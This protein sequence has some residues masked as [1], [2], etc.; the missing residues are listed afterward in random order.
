MSGLLARPN[1][2]RVAPRYRN[3][4]VLATCAGLIAGPV[5]GAQ[6]AHPITLTGLN[7]GTVNVGEA[8]KV[9]TVRF[10][11]DTGG[12]LDSMQPFQVVTQGA[13][14]L[15]FVSAAGATCNGT[16]SYS[17]G[18]TCQVNVRFNPK[19]PGPRYGAVLLYGSAGSVIATAY[20]YGTGTGP[21]VTFSPGPSSSVPD[22]SPSLLG[23]AVDASGDVFL[24]HQKGL[25][26]KD[27]PSGGGYIQSTVGDIEPNNGY[28]NGITVDGAGNIFATNA[29]HVY[30]ESPSGT[31]YTQSVAFG[32]LANSEQIAVD[33]SG[34]LFITEIEPGRVV[35]AVPSS[36]GY[37][38]SIIATGILLPGAITVD[39]S[40]NVYVG[41]RQGSPG[42][43]GGV[44]KLTQ[45]G[46]TYT[47]ST[48]VEALSVSGVAV[49]AAGDVYFSGAD[50]S[51]SSGNYPGAVY[52]AAP[53]A[54]GYVQGT[55]VSGL[56]DPGS[57]E[58]DQSGN[59]YVINNVVNDEEV[60]KET[61][62]VPPSLAFA[63]TA[64]GSISS[65]S[66]QT[67]TVSNIG[68]ATLTFPV[69]ESGDNPAISENFTLDSGSDAE[70]PLTTASSSAGTVA[71]GASCP[72]PI[73]FAPEPP[74]YGSVSGTLKL[75]D[76]TLNAASPGYAVQSITLTAAVS[77]AP[78]FGSLAAPVDSV[79]GSSTVSQSDSVVIQGW[80]ADPMDHAPVS[81][82]TVYMDGASVGTPTL[83][84][85]RP[86]VAKDYGSADLDSGYQMLY[87]AASLAVGAHHV[88]VTAIDSSGYS[89][90]F[91][92]AS[93]TVTA[94]GA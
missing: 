49:D 32:G 90:T 25:I 9:G 45:S 78:P 4:A 22:G 80:V 62:G 11:F 37:T 92:P 46:G 75:R 65:D 74:A 77:S 38:H 61:L 55:V 35:K 93:F 48:V 66:P 73:N 28:T 87:P 41:D 6:T 52:R 10:M 59:L 68:N 18:G 69:P 15:D 94:P 20:V 14:N 3:A 43:G 5:C 54:D 33:G 2:I 39:G 86:T 60:L 40:G 34:N 76:D 7:L 21:L 13:P 17:A 88:K 30:E 56:N 91:G 71:A 12:N 53:S 16:T 63:A 58:L 47:Q 42:N 70:C 19:Y 81:N 57:T 44:Y 83:G 89:K 23:L 67:V 27:T 64:N 79:S 36:T 85:A 24:V 82:V 50:P 8:S 72:L 51:Y 31:T 84:L 1:W 26:L 29:G